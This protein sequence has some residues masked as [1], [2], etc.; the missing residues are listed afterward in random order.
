MKF[1]L[2]IA[3]DIYNILECGHSLF[4]FVVFSRLFSLERARKQEIVA[5]NSS[6]NHK[7]GTEKNVTAAAR[8][9]DF[10]LCPQI[11]AA[12]LLHSLPSRATQLRLIFN[13]STDSQAPPQGG[14][15][16]CHDLHGGFH[17]SL[18]GLAR[19]LQQFLWKPNLCVATPLIKEARA[20]MQITPEAQETWVSLNILSPSRI[21]LL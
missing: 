21:I 19:T 1:K 16:F 13:A 6:A 7:N 14:A 3:G 11:M 5:K 9:V 12:R 4:Y 2:H 8:A 17:A 18:P 10:H 20:I 15:H